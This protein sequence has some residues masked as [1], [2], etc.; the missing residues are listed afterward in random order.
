MAAAVASPPPTPPPRVEGAS[1]APP[2]AWA[3][4]S[5]TSLW[6]AYGS[7]CWS[8]AGKAACADMIP[9]AQRRDLR[10][11]RARR[12]RTIVVRL[13]FSRLEHRGDRRRPRSRPRDWEHGLV[14]GCAGG[15]C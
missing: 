10:V 4:I 5:R 6:L 7:Y 8:E 2:P 13:R 15:H 9:P 12:S 11:I 14:A 1:V 3:E